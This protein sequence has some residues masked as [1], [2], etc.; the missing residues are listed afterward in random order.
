MNAADPFEGPY[1]VS[2]PNWTGAAYADGGIVRMGEPWGPLNGPFVNGAASTISGV[3]STTAQPGAIQLTESNSLG[4]APTTINVGSSLTLTTTG[5]SSIIGMGGDSRLAAERLAVRRFYHW[6]K[7]ATAGAAGMRGTAGGPRTPQ[8]EDTADTHTVPK[9]LV[10]ATD[11]VQVTDSAAVQVLEDQVLKIREQGHRRG[12]RRRLVRGTVLSPRSL[13]RVAVVLAGQKRSIVGEEWQ[14]HLLGEPDGGLTQ[15]QQIRAARG[16]VLAAVRY[17][18]QD[19]ADQA[20]RPVDAVLRSRG[21]SN[22]FVLIPTV[23]VAMLVLHHE[24]T[25][26][27]VTSAESIVAIGGTLYGLIRVGRWYRYVKLP[28]PKAKRA[29][30]KQ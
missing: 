13:T 17:R 8:K 28:D 11:A 16:F 23:M 5:G 15:R 20:W 18:L 14:G 29:R 30:E 2:G 10:T 9:V 27:M 22:L 24:G 21:L 19:A 4:A 1:A 7:S 6:N 26:G 12:N 25:L 3:A